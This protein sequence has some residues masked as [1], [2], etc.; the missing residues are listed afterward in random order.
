M[1]APRVFTTK[2]LAQVGKLIDQLTDEEADAIAS[3]NAWLSLT[4]ERP[5]PQ[6]PRTVSAGKSRTPKAQKQSK[7][8]LN[9]ETLVQSLQGSR[10]RDEANAVLLGAGKLGKTDLIAILE[11]LGEIPPKSATI[12]KLMDNIVEIVVGIRSDARSILGRHFQ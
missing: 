9:V 8:V 3:G 2:L 1:S 4:I 10:N 12:A 5:A 6:E 11:A 7:P